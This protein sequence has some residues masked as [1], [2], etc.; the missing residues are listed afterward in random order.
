MVTFSQ[1]DNELGLIILNWMALEQIK[2]FIIKIVDINVLDLLVILKRVLDI[3]LLT[4]ERGALLIFVIHLLDSIWFT[5]L[6]RNGN[7]EHLTVNYTVTRCTII[8]KRNGTPWG[9]R[10]F[11]NVFSSLFNVILHY[12]SPAYHK[13]KAYLSY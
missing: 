9:V 13:W 10:F 7:K 3:L 5:S 11:A 4:V 6:Q 8:R 2:S 1:C 12:V